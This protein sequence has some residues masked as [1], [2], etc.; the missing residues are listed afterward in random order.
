MD[1]RV[2]PRRYHFQSVRIIVMGA[3]AVVVDHPMSLQWGHILLHQFTFMMIE[4]Q[5]SLIQLGPLYYMED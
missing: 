2:Y 1:K 3:A 4:C 5:H